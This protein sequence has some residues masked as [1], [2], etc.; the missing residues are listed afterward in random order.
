MLIDTHAHLFD[1]RFDKDL[2][3]VLE[4]AAT[5]VERV[6]CLGID[7]ESS[8]A[9]VA[10]ANRFPLVVAAVGI[11]PNSVAEAKPGDWDEVVRLAETEAARRRDRRN[12]PRPLL[13]PDAVPQQE[14]FFARHI[15]LARRLEQAVRD[16]LPRSGSRRG[17]DAARGVRADTAPCGRSCTRSAATSRPRRRVWRWGSTSRSREC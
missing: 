14:E 12:R 16:P 2:P 7:R 10:I 17:E 9:S 4:R 5:A 8:L 3:A 6:V 13:G 1:D 11:Q 15:E